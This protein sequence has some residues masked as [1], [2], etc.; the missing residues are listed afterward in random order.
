M[1][2]ADD[3]RFEAFFSDEQQRLVGAVALLTGNRD[4]AAEAVADAIARAWERVAKGEEIDNLA[5]WIRVVAFNS[6]RGTFRR[7]RSERLA[8]ERLKVSQSLVESDITEPA[9]EMQ[10]LLAQL[11]RR[12]REV[13]VMRYFLDL[14]VEEIGVE[15]EIGETTVRNFLRRAR[16][17]LLGIIEAK[18]DDDRVNDTEVRRAVH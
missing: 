18:R 11:P 4:V 7:R 12:Q 1:G 2:A 3:P 15:L 16:A 5:A 6:A 10:E 13:I 17:R 14:S 9:S 8:V